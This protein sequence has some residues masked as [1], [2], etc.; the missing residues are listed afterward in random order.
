[1][2]FYVL[3]V[4]WKFNALYHIHFLFHFIRLFHSKITRIIRCSFKSVKDQCYKV[5]IYYS[6]F[7]CTRINK[8]KCG[9]KS[10]HCLWREKS[11]QLVYTANVSKK[12][13]M[14]PIAHKDETLIYE[15]LLDDVINDNLECWLELFH[16]T[17]FFYLLTINITMH[18]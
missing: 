13:G 11:V 3:L 8:S 17:V 1:M 10:I 5:H 14:H 16:F 2:S 12:Y 7:R 6:Y 4:Q 9:K 18:M 15:L